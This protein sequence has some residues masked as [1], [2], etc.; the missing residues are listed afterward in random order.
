MLSCFSCR[1][2]NAITPLPSGSGNSF[3]FLSYDLFSTPRSF[4]GLPIPPVVAACDEG[5]DEDVDLEL[6]L[7]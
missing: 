7:F 6:R 2:E 1:R 4:L 3:A 5:S